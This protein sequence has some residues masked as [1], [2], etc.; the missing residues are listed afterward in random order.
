MCNENCC[1][2]GCTKDQKQAKDQIQENGFYLQQT[3][4][5]VQEN[6]IRFYLNQI[7]AAISIPTPEEIAEGHDAFKP[8]YLITAVKLPT[9][10]IELAIN[11]E[12]IEAKIDYILEAYDD[13]M[14]LKSNTVIQMA[15]I[16]VV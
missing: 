8:S 12:N 5:Q 7:K 13:N 4:D 16:M 2:C 3:K 1:E 6:E 9:G 10:A 15:N 11:T 14:H